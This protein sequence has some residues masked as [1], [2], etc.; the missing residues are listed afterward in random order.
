MIHTTEP[1][2]IIRIHDGP[3]PPIPAPLHNNQTFLAAHLTS[4]LLCGALVTF[5]GLVRVEE[6]GQLISGLTYELYE[7]MAQSQLDTLARTTIQTFGLALLHVEHSRGFVPTGACSF[8]L[9]IAS[10]HRKEALAAMDHFIDEM[11]RHVP[12][13]KRADHPS[14]TT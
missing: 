4:P 12:I 5:E 7:G 1:S 9:I 10:P 13:W 11:K 2:C 8:R 6:S 14:I 3:L